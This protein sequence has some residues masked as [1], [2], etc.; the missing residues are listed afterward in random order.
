MA[1]TTTFTGIT[2]KGYDIDFDVYGQEEYTVFFEGDDLYFN[3]LSEAKS[4]ID[5][6]LAMCE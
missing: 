2:Y 5:S 6:M 4:F 1:S 3:T